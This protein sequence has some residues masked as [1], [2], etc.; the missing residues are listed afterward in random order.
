[1]YY[2]TKTLILLV[3]L[4]TLS[5]IAQKGSSFYDFTKLQSE[6]TVPNDITASLESLIDQEINTFLPD[7]LKDNKNAHKFLQS[8]HLTARRTFQSGKVLFGDTLTNYVN[9]VADKLLENDPILRK[10]IRIYV[11][12][13]P[14][15]NAFAFHQG[16]VMINTGLIA[17]ANSE[18]D[19]AF[20]IGHEIGH[21]IQRHSFNSY[22]ANREEVRKSRDL[23]YKE[24]LDSVLS[25]SRK[26]E[27]ES[28]SIGVE[29]LKNSNY[30]CSRVQNSLELLHYSYLPIKNTPFPADFFNT[31]SFVIPHCFFLKSVN[32]ISPIETPNSDINL[33]HPNVLR[34]IEKTN[35]ML[36]NNCSQKDVM[37]NDNEFQYIKT[38]AQFE[39][40]NTLLENH[41]YAETIYSAFALMQDHPQNKFLL[42]AINKAFYALAMYKN[43][44]KFHIATKSYSQVEGES[45]QIYYMLRRLTKKQIN[46]LALHNLYNTHLLHPNDE[47]VKIL[48]KDLVENIIVKE[49]LDFDEFK[50]A[51]KKLAIGGEFFERPSMTDK[52]TRILLEKKLKLFYLNAF[53]ESD[54]STDLFKEA[55]KEGEI[56]KKQEK[57]EYYDKIT[58]LQKEIKNRNLVI[59][60]PYNSYVNK[61]KML[62]SEKSAMNTDKIIRSLNTIDAMLPNSSFKIKK[63]AGLNAKSVENWNQINLVK[64]WIKENKYKTIIP[65]LSDQVERLT[66]LDKNDI[67]VEIQS[68]S[69]KYDTYFVIR[70]YDYKKKELLFADSFTLSKGDFK[71]KKLLKKFIKLFIKY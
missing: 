30:S 7:E 14:Y 65:S 43:L 18:E 37:D 51:S 19:L 58:H 28:D 8:T 24:K 31:E 61:D 15:V 11:H 16:I 71:E 25:R 67:I 46:T 57:K 12:N 44:N 69:D 29:M 49:V 23:S 40:I 55:I 59:I 22:L 27:F 9:K 5:C 36:T 10:E 32:E 34:R 56:A 47:Y 48:F 42:R 39:Y 60:A 52:K 68:K 63:Y 3:F 26:H 35:S 62:D 13:S 64:S 2:S 4:I 1:M 21:Y 17:K 6:G 45:Q 50:D 41:H 38:V 70:F 20:T 54:L 66:D 33:T 53:N